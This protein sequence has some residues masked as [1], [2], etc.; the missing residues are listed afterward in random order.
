MYISH[1][2]VSPVIAGYIYT[3]YIDDFGPIVHIKRAPTL[4]LFYMNIQA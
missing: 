1:M 3:I 2:W 4:R